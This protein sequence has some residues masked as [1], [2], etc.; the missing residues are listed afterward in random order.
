MGSVVNRA[1]QGTA[2]VRPYEAVLDIAAERAATI[3]SGLAHHFNSAGAA[4]PSTGVVERVVQHLRQEQ[5][6]GG[7]EAAAA[8]APQVEA[9]YDSAARLIGARAREIA[10]FD[11]AST[12]LKAIVEAM[13][14]DGTRRL[15]VS[16]STYVSHALHLLTISREHGGEVVIVP[17][18]PDGALDLVVLDELLDGGPAIVCVAHIPTSSGLVEPV[19]AVGELCRRHGATYVLDA[20]QSV[21]HI[22]VDV[23]TIGCDALVT[24]G[25]KFLRAPRGTGF[26]YVSADL[27]SRLE[28]TAPDVRGA[29]WTGAR[30]FTLSDTARRFETWESAVAGRLGLGVAIDEA[31]ARGITTS[32]AYLVMGGATLREQLTQIPGVRVQDPAAARSGIVTFTIDG[33][34]AAEVTRRLVTRR[35][36]TVSVPATHAQWDLG[37]RG[38][39]AVVRASLHVYNDTSDLE[40]LVDG[41][42]DIVAT[43]RSEA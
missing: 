39:D 3:G 30:T 22:T 2:G 14:L 20:T 17:N 28:P 43:H 4:L 8:I 19:E 7:Y 23:A 41:V 40:A 13:R 9:V 35:V 10:L 5:E 37:D 33:L 27:L 12:G 1:P 26:A 6:V 29:I 31:L 24:T 16:A 25:R 38:V 36:R 18:G 15:L 42:G 21:G 11:S 32:E 34:A